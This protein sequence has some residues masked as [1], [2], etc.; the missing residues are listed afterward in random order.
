MTIWSNS[1]SDKCRLFYEPVSTPCGHTFCKNCLER[2]L[3]HTPHCPLCKESLKQVRGQLWHNWPK[4]HCLMN[5][6]MCTPFCDFIITGYFALSPVFSVQ[7]VHGDNSLGHADQ[8]V[9]ESGVRREDENPRGWDERA[10]RVSPPD[11]R[12]HSPSNVARGS[13]DLKTWTVSFSTAWR[14]MCLSLCAPWLTPLCLVLFTSSSHV[15]ASWSAAAWKQA[16]GS[17]ACVLMILRKG[18]FSGML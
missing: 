17:S 2:C 8:A 11:G 1:L 12:T 7:E 13:K 10:V 6:S 9:F 18:G 5:R 16:R 14:R 4:Q 3:D 15:T